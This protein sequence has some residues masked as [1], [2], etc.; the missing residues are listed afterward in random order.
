M[1]TFWDT[2]HLDLGDTTNADIWQRSSELHDRVRNAHSRERA[3]ILQARMGDL[4]GVPDLVGRDWLSS[5]AVF[6][7]GSAYSPFIAGV[8]GRSHAMSLDAYENASSAR[9]FQE[10]FIPRVVQG[11]SS[12]Y[13]ALATL[14][15]P[16]VGSAERVLLTDLVRA[17]FIE[18]VGET[19]GDGAVRADPELFMAYARANWRWTWQ[20][21]RQSEATVILALGT[22]AER[23]LLELMTG[24]GL[25][26]TRRGTS[27]QLPDGPVTEYAGGTIGSWLD[28]QTWWELSGR[29]DARK[30]T[31]KV[32]PVY[33]PAWF[34][35]YDAGYTRTREVLEMMLGRRARPTAP[36]PSSS[37]SGFIAPP[38]GRSSDNT[39]QGMHFVCRDDMNVVDHGDGTFDSGFWKVGRRHCDTVEYIALHNTKDEWSYR[40]G[41][42]I[43]WRTC[44]YQGA[45]RVIFTVEADSQP[46][47]W[48]GGGS[49]EKGYRYI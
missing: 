44:E 5:D 32:L 18:S 28:T 47:A 19:G 42:V 16:I 26:L 8:A 31:W 37:R 11:D 33:H 40:Q 22:I 38:T 29:V 9:E 48:C 24:R 30:H 46:R 41:R 14:L 7:V 20:R 43:D 34:N 12:Y 4:P 35:R 45:T 36:R 27:F 3:D 2:D 6:V 13:G 23:G 15:R 17:C 25:T 49:G 10:V 39:V 21:L 1:S